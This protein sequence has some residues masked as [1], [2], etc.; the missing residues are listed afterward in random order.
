VS[1]GPRRHTTRLLL[2]GAFFLSSLSACGEEALPP[3]EVVETVYFADDHDEKINVQ[4]GQ[5]FAIALPT[6]TKVAKMVRRDPRRP[7]VDG[8]VLTMREMGSIPDAWVDE[9]GGEGTAYLIDVLSE[10]NSK[11]TIFDA[12]HRERFRLVVYSGD[13]AQAK[14]KSEA[15]KRAKK[16]KK[17]RRGN[18]TRTRPELDQRVVGKDG[19]TV[20]ARPATPPASTKAQPIGVTKP[21]KGRDPADPGGR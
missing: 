5:S 13:K 3:V 1:R 14:A 11:V 15:D 8:K 4:P 21:V 16:K 10:G 17:D 6:E 12:A 7:R 20:E 2:G 19:K 18:P 9:A